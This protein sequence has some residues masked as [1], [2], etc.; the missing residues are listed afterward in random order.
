MVLWEAVDLQE[1]SL[2]SAAV[3]SGAI[4]VSLLRL[5]LASIIITNADL[6]YKVFTDYSST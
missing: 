1:I 5:F 2:Y 6:I 3:A 4:L